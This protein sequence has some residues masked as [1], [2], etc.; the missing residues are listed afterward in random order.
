MTCDDVQRALLEFDDPART[1][2]EPAIAAHVATCAACASAVAVARRL[3]GMLTNALA[4]PTLSPSFRAALYRRLDA[5]PSPLPSPTLDAV[6]DVLH[7]AGCATLTAYCAF[8]FPAH[9]TLVT[10]LGTVATVTTYMMLALTKNLLDD[11]R[12]PG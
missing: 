12:R 9:T 11:M 2:A 3:D 4:P 5:R 7:L 10:A 8:A 1:A 6:P